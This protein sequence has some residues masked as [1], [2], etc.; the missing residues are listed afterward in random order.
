MVRRRQQ[1]QLKALLLMA[2]AQLKARVLLMVRRRQQA[3]LKA[4]L[5]MARVPLVT[6]VLLELLAPLAVQVVQ[7]P[8]LL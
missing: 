2:R 6:R 3:Q 5:L 4:L 7:A 1:A 8:D